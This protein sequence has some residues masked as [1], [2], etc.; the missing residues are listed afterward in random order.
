MSSFKDSDDGDMLAFVAAAARV[1][2]LEL[3]DARVRSVAMNLGRTLTMARQLESFDL[4]PEVEPA[5][6]FRPAPFTK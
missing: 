6:L 2:G 1:A 3:D 5:E 4:P